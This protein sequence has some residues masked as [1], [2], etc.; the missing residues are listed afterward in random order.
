MTD[1]FTCKQGLNGH[2]LA[3]DF[4]INVAS[5]IAAAAIPVFDAA[6]AASLEVDFATATAALI[7]VCAHAPAPA[8]I[9]SAAAA[10]DTNVDVAAVFVYVSAVIL[11]WS[12]FI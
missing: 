6:P 1:A 5:A 4:V 11:L 12:Y 8:P 9:S 3:A 7:G 10:F 2:L